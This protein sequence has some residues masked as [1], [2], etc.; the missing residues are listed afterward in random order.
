MSTNPSF[1]DPPFSK[2]RA[3]IFPIQNSEL[4]KFLPMALMMFLIL[5]NYTLLRNTK[6]TL[7]VTAPGSGAEIISFI[8]ILDIPCAILFFFIYAKLSNILSRPALFYTCLIPFLVFFCVFAFFLYPNKDLLHPSLESVLAL[9]ATYP[10][11]KWFIS[12]YGIWSFA[13]FYILAEFWG[14]IVISLLFWQFANEITRTGE[15][16]RFYVFFP[17]LGNLALVSTGALGKWVSEAS[18]CS[19]DGDPWSSMLTYTVTAVIIAGIAI[20]L[21]YAWMDKYVL[22][23]PLYYDEA[24]RKNKKDKPKLSLKE[25]IAYLFSSKYL[26]FIT[27]LLLSY[28]I[29]SNFIDVAWKGQVQAYFPNSHDYFEFM[30]RFSF[31]TGIMTIVLVFMTKGIVRRFGWF[32]GAIITPTVLLISSLL[33]FSLVLFK[34]SL[35]GVVALLGVTSL[36]LAVMVGA[37]QNIFNKAAKYSLFDPTKEMAYIPL[38]QELKVKG[39]AA[40]DVIGGRLGKSSGGFIQSFLLVLTAGSLTTIAPYL[41][42]ILLI[43]ILAW[44]GSANGLSKL[45]NAKVKQGE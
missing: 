10:H 3:S 25:S 36:Y 11:L 9:Q 5:F 4:K 44:M 33:F 27:V 18:R 13:L 20:L 19:A 28:G 29:V 37:V 21:I 16:K 17:L 40:V 45:Y 23:D 2:L 24:G 39:K 12:L 31:W 38:D 41:L 43:V 1:Q 34:E 8:K 32:A 6:D 7:V 15:A 30:C 42:G 22:T 26:G 35:E 14:S